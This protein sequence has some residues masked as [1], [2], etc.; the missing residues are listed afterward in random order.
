MKR[1]L[2]LLL[3]AV[4]LLVLG[5]AVKLS[6]VGPYEQPIPVQ[7]EESCNREA[8]QQ[9]KSCNEKSDDKEGC[10]KYFEC[11]RDACAAIRKGESPAGCKMR[12]P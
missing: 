2:S 8:A 10:R 5:A 9:F 1:R 12:L 7:Q 11:L 4:S 6:A 3:I